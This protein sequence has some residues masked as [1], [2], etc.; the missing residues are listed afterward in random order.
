[1]VD[2]SLI[3]LNSPLISFF[4]TRLCFFIHTSDR[5]S[6]QVGVCI[7]RETPLGEV[8]LSLSPLVHFLVGFSQLLERRVMSR[9]RVRSSDLETSLPSS[10]KI[11][12]QEMDTT[13]SHLLTFQAWK[14]KCGYPK[15][16]Y[17]KTRD[18]IV[19]KY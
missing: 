6:P 13:S 9:D 12:A 7:T 1:M 10:E 15:K 11:I 19:N 8:L 14:E 5:E 17:E 2:Y 4:F 18:R 16:D 3:W